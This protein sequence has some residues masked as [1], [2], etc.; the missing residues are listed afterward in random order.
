MRVAIIT[1]RYEAGS[2]MRLGSMIH[3]FIVFTTSPPAMSAPLASKK[4]A[5]T[6]AH[7]SVIALAQT[8]GPILFAT[9]FAQIFIAIYIQNKLAITRRIDA[10]P[11]MFG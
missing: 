5:I 6:I 1:A 3:F 11:L 9:S 4:A 8:A 2:G 7:Q 10:S